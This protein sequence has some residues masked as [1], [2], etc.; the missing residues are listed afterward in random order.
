MALPDTVIA[1]RI[2]MK[3]INGEY[4]ALVL[5]CAYTSRWLSAQS[6]ARQAEALPSEH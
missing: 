6:V 2:P 3:L 5:T 4:D 1:G